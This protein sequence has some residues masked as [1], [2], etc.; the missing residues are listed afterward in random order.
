MVVP[1]FAVGAVKMA[2]AVDWLRTNGKVLISFVVSPSAMLRRA[3]S[4]HKANQLVQGFLK[5]A[6][7]LGSNGGW[8]WPSAARYVPVSCVGSCSFSLSLPYRSR[9]DVEK[10]AVFHL[11]GGRERAF[12]VSAR[13]AFGGC[14][15]RSTR[16]GNLCPTR[17]GSHPHSFQCTRRAPGHDGAQLAKRH[18]PRGLIDFPGGLD[19][20]GSLA[21]LMFMQ[22]LVPTHTVPDDG[23]N[24]RQDREHRYSAAQPS[25]R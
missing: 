17:L 7:Q 24:L 22:S 3:L 6:A 5:V 16:V 8:R 25:A 23:Q 10:L 20:A 1:G 9:H 11:P 2:E 12:T 18:Q 13:L 19:D 14:P 4:D 21:V 15:C